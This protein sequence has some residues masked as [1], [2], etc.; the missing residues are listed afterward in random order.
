MKFFVLSPID[1]IPTPCREKSKQY[2]E[3]GVIEERP[4]TKFHVYIAMHTTL[5]E[6]CVFR[7][8]KKNMD[9]KGNI[10]SSKIMFSHLVFFTYLVP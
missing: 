7:M 4:D 1:E 3:Q 9:T 2:G 8:K 10:C 6:S 5:I